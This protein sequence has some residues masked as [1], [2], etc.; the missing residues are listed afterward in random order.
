M[1]APVFY[2]L[3]GPNGAGKS[4][5]YRAAVAERLIPV[6]AEFVN[7]DL[8][9]V[10]HLQ[11]LADPQASYRQGDALREAVLRDYVLNTHN[12]QQWANGWLAD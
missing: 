2:L 6:S 11:H 12:L 5:L 8:Y 3:A 1:P 7:A 10:A 9:E 4:T